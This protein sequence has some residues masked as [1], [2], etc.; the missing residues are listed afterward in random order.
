M[1]LMIAY[2]SFLFLLDISKIDG[3][4]PRGYGLAFLFC[5]ENS[6]QVCKLDFHSKFHLALHRE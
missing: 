5:E 4:V 2:E 3:M 1:C 6:A